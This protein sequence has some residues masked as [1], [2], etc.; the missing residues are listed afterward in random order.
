MVQGKLSVSVTTRLSHGDHL[1]LQELAE[2][3]SLDVSAIVRSLIRTA[4]SSDLS[5]SAP[6]QK[7][8]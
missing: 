5:L 4:G 8:G 1:K 2:R 7:T 3:H 6:P